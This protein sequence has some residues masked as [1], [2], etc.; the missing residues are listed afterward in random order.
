MC[1]TDDD[2]DGILDE[3]DNC[4]LTANADQLDTDGD[5]VGDVCGDPE[6]LFIE[7]INFIENIYPVPTEDN[8]RVTFDIHLDVKDLYFID[9]FGRVIRPRSYINLPDGLDVNVSNLNEGIYLL[10]ILSDKKKS[11]IKIIIRR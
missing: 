8:L 1:D 11:K 6:P 2:G 9:I 3:S 10:K 5:G 7:N 4:P